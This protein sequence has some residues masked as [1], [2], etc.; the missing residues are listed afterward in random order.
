[1]VFRSPRALGDLKISKVSKYLL[2]KY[3]GA[4]TLFVCS[5][6]SDLSSIGFL[7]VP[8]GSAGFLG[9]LLGS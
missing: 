8:K 2:S 6:C 4:F 9:V 7:G 3:Y 5:L 1:M